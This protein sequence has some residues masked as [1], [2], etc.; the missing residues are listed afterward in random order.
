MK[1]AICWWLGCDPDYEHVRHDMIAPCK[2]CGALDTSYADR[3]GDTRQRRLMDA[4]DGAIRFFWPRKC[5]ECGK[6]RGHA[7]DCIP[8]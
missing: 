6:R 8:F 1:R 5:V 7:D 4:L 2:R 3:V